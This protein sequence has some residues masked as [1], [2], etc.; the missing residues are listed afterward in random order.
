MVLP[1]RQIHRGAVDAL[2]PAAPGHGGGG[3]TWVA[4]D[5]H[6]DVRGAATWTASGPG[7]GPGSDRSERTRTLVAAAAHRL[8]SP[9]A[10]ELLIADA[11]AEY[12]DRGVTCLELGR[13]RRAVWWPG[14]GDDLRPDVRRPAGTVVDRFGQP[15]QPRWLALHSGWALPAAAAAL[16]GHAGC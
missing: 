11:V 1:C 5:R 12:R 14:L 2:F 15:W 8:V 4:V 9:G 10:G 6:G 16:H 13:R 3:E 7:G